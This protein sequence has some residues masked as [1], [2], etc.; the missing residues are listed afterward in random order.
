M[1]IGF[2]SLGCPKN[3]VDSEV[4]M[5]LLEAR[6]HP[7][8]QRSGDAE[9]LV[10]NT[11]SFI[12]PAKQESVDAILEMAEYK[13]TGRARRLWSPAALLSATVGSCKRKFPRWTPFWHVGTNEIESIVSRCEGGGEDIPPPPGGYLYHDLTPRKRATPKRFRLPENQRRLR[14]SLHV[15]HHS[16]ISRTLPQAVVSSR[17]C[18]RLRTFSPPECAKST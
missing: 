11:C 10:V 17:S 14:S 13:K 15:L 7:T 6:G 8:H 4:M 9:A 2:V 12:D 1:K 5:G 16:A 18:A 3:L